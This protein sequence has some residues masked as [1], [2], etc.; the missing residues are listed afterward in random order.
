MNFA[1][2][3]WKLLVVLALMV[4][5]TSSASALRI[6]MP[7]LTTT[8]K[9]MKADAVVTGKV[10]EIEKDT[11][12]ATPFPNN[13]TKV[14]YQVGV[15]KI[16]TALLGAKDLT[17]IRVGWQMAVN[18]PN[19]P[20][21]GGKIRLSS[22]IPNQIIALQQ[23][24]EGCFFLK[25]HPT[26]DFYVIVPFATPLDKKA[27]NFDKELA[28]IK[29]VQEILSK[30][31]DALKA[32]KAEDRQVAASVLLQRYGQYPEVVDPKQRPKQEPINEEESKLIMKAISELEWINNTD[33]SMSLGN[34][35]GSLNLTP[36]DGW[37][38]P[39]FNGMG[40]FNKMMKETFDKWYKENG[41][42]YRIKKWVLEK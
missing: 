25:K 19:N 3:Q 37:K 34:L 35:F 1:T 29:K 26:T 9:A 31:V 41:E 30:P 22:R 36:N 40:D 32:E 14:A 6:A 20:E 10:V 39:Q 18:Q 15:I 2:K 7:N 16:D 33:P 24:Q 28:S 5:W 23:G 27:E 17:Q 21:I 13:P 11:V 42:K 38:P 8:Q 12:E 4:G